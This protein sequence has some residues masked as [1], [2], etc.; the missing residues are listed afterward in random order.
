MKALSAVLALCVCGL[1]LSGCVVRRYT[2]TQEPADQNLKEGNLGYVEGDVPLPPERQVNP[3]SKIVQVELHPLIKFDGPAKKKPVEPQVPVTATVT[4]VQTDQQLVIEE[5][6]VQPG[7]TLQKIAKKYYGQ[8]GRWNEIFQANKG[9]MDSP[10]KIYPGKILKI[11]L[12][13]AAGTPSSSN[14]GHP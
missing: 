7:D 2:V 8:S 6:I 13:K 9:T 3:A 14:E 1:L 11:P 10:D 4:V 12:M 5:Y